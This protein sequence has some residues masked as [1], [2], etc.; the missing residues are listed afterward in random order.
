[1]NGPVENYRDNGKLSSSGEYKNNLFHGHWK[2][3]HWDNYLE[4]EGD[5]KK[6]KPVGVWKAYYPDGNLYC[7][8]KHEYIE[9][10]SGQNRIYKYY[11]K[12]GNCTKIEEYKNGKIINS[13]VYDSEWEKDKDLNENL[14][15]E[16][17]L[18]NEDFIGKGKKDKNGLKQEIGRAHV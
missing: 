10:S 6:G 8:A 2:Y 9:Y 17:I 16:D 12:D 4:E 1:M 3:Y 11:D 18:N 15:N 13:K 5:W 14:L 7:L